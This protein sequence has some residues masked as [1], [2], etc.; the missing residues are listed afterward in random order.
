MRFFAVCHALRG[1]ERHELYDMYETNGDAACL[2]VWLQFLLFHVL[3]LLKGFWCKARLK[4]APE[5]AK[6]KA[7]DLQFPVVAKLYSESPTVVAVFGAQSAT[8]PAPNVFQA[9]V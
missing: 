6:C 8:P 9:H 1:C 2:A 5:L 3:F 4:P 7:M